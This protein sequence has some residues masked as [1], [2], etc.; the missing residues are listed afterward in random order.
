MD[1]SNETRA[2]GA[3]KLKYCTKGVGGDSSCNLQVTVDSRHLDQYT[4]EVERVIND[5]PYNA[6]KISL[7]NTPS[8]SKAIELVN[9]AKS[10][11]LIPIISSGT[12]SRVLRDGDNSIFFCSPDDFDADFCVGIGGL[13]YHGNGVYETEFS[14]RLNRFQDIQREYEKI[15]FVG[16][17]FHVGGH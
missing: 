15:R 14:N 12:G 16:T 13:Q 7:V 5:M 9:K 11:K 2:T 4:V 10:L 17:R 1:I 6:F 3:D 8:I